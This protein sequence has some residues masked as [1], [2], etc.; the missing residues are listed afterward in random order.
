MCRLASWSGNVLIGVS[1][2]LYSWAANPS[3]RAPSVRASR[4][5]DGCGVAWVRLEV[6]NSP[7]EAFVVAHERMH[8]GHVGRSGL[9]RYTT[10]GTSNRIAAE[11]E[12]FCALVNPVLLE[13][14]VSG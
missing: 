4:C 12:A 6:V 2:A 3:D 9:V 8:V 10:I 13:R 1:S 7:M 14:D 5:E 11:A